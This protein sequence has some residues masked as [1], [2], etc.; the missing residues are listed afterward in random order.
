MKPVFVAIFMVIVVV[1]VTDTT[2]LLQCGENEAHG[3]EPCCPQSEV[4]CQNKV[5]LPCNKPCVHICKTKCVCAAGYLRD[6]NSGKCVKD[7]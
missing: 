4:T 1:A 6:T 7:C 5:A 3:C 2:A